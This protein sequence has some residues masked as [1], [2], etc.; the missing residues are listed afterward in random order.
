MYKFLALLTLKIVSSRNILLVTTDD[1]TSTI[2]DS[3]PKHSFF[4]SANLFNAITP[5]SVCGPSRAALLTGLR[6]DTTKNYNFETYIHQETMFSYFKNIGYDTFVT[7]KVFHTLPINKN[8]QFEYNIGSLTSPRTC[9]ESGNSGCRGK[10]FCK[11][12]L[13]EDSCSIKSAINFFKSRAGKKTNWIAGIGFHRPHLAITLVSKKS[14]LCKRYI[15]DSNFKVPTNFKYSLSNIEHTKLGN[16]KVPINKLFMPIVSKT[17]KYPSDLFT[18]KYKNTI[19]QMRQAYCDSSTETIMHFLKIVDSMYTILPESVN[20]TDI[21]FISDHGFHIGERQIIGKNT[22]Y[23]EATNIP[24]FFKIGGETIKRPV[25]KQYFSSID[26][27]STLIQLHNPKSTKKL[28]GVSLFGQEKSIPISQYPRCQ[29]LGTLQTDECTTGDNSCPTG[30]RLK[31][32]YMG[33]M[34]IQEISGIVYRF[35]EWFVYNEIRKCDWP[36][37]PGIPS[38]LVGNLGEWPVWNLQPTSYTDFSNSFNQELYTIDNNQLINS[39][40]L[41]NKREYL[42]IVRQMDKIIKENA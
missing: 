1:M 23:P 12:K 40:N 21:V 24:L 11:V 9:L 38:Q 26:I 15:N 22:L 42:E 7:G 32:T 16:I 5:I 30:G 41:A 29:N 37:W 27:F 39:E 31:I 17:R 35:S 34:T 3:Y 8:K 36:S 13:S 2:F 25:K 6:P 19:R 18:D 14:D 33:Y 28:D 20:N 4:N 10:F